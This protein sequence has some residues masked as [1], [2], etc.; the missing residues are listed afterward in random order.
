M[1]ML[2]VHVTFGH[3]K[4]NILNYV[5]IVYNTMVASHSAKG[6]FG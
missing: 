3:N 5:V 2:H 1:S 6:L 4:D